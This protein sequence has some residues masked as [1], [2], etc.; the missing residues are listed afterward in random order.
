MCLRHDCQA[1]VH[2]EFQN[3]YNNSVTLPG[4]L[5]IRQPTRDNAS[6]KRI[7]EYNASGPTPSTYVIDI[8]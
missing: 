2:D 4:A 1:P 3:L 7:L 8:E 5:T 6:I